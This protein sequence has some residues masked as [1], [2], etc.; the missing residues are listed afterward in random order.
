MRRFAIIGHRAVTDPGFSLNDMPGS[1]G[2][3]DV[4]CRC[5]NASFFLS[6]DLRRDVECYLI[7]KDG[8]ET[9]ILFKGETVRSLNPDERSAGALI[10]KALAKT[11]GSEF[12]ES[13]P[14]VFIRRGGLDRLLSEFSFAI[15]DESGADI[16]GMDNLPENLLLSDH[17]NFTEAEEELIAP[18]PRV[19]VGPLVLHADHTITVYQNEV[20]R[21]GV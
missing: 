2:R 4:L 15:L 7:L 11:C 5:V 21:R 18:L 14:G 3:M 13:S 16:R 12:V 9:T 19:S 6:H 20:D 1:A 8:M 17:Q 10:K